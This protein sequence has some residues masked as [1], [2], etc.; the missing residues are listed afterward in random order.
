M[1]SDFTDPAPPRDDE[2]AS[3]IDPQTLLEDLAALHGLAVTAETLARRLGQQDVHLDRTQR[4]ALETCHDNARSI[5]A[6]LDRVV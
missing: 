2:V 4:S 6:S 3:D 5:V 1:A